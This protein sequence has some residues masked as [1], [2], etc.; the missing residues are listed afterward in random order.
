MLLI[1]CF[2]ASKYAS[3]LY[4]RLIPLY[5]P[6]IGAKNSLGVSLAAIIICSIT[7][8]ILRFPTNVSHGHRSNIARNWVHKPTENL[9]LN[10]ST[11]KICDVKL[12]FR[13]TVKMAPRF[14]DDY[15]VSYPK[16]EI[17]YCP[18]FSLFFP[19]RARDTDSFFRTRCLT[20]RYRIASYQFHTHQ[21]D[22]LHA[23][24]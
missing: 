8:F 18:S 5:A 4:S 6:T 21:I 23:L 1:R 12:I 11:F 22:Q 10:G 24:G 19:I 15:Q 17:R 3:I 20:A 14:F 7:R 16:M 2:F 9:A 13:F